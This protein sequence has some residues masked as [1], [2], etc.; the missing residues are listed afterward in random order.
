MDAG[1]REEVVHSHECVV[2]IDHP[3]RGKRGWV[4]D[5]G[6]QTVADPILAMTPCS[7]GH[8]RFLASRLG[9]HQ[10]RDCGVEK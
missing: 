10:L 1:F 2:V 6:T 4:V 9:C 3:R 7:H 5:V 8:W